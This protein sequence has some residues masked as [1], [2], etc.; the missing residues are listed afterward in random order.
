MDNKQAQQIFEE[1]PAFFANFGKALDNILDGKLLSEE[2]NWEVKGKLGF[3]VWRQGN[4]VVG[5]VRNVNDE[6]RETLYTP[7][8]GRPLPNHQGDRDAI[9]E[10]SDLIG[11]NCNS[12]FTYDDIE[13]LFSKDDL[14]KYD[15]LC[16]KF[17]EFTD[18]KNNMELWEMVQQ[19]SE[20]RAILED[21]ERIRNKYDFLKGDVFF[22]VWNLDGS[23]KHYKEICY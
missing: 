20:L 10:I 11:R 1:N 19:P 6:I 3:K 5:A 12:K 4:N 21:I 13:R 14:S 2:Y 9:K 23:A 16:S 15:L 17:V 8:P 7:E 18:G 22:K